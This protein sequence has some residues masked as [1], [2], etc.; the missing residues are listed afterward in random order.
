MNATKKVRKSEKVTELGKCPSCGLPLY[1]D[2]YGS[3]PLKD[4]ELK[5]FNDLQE[6]LIVCNSCLSNPED[7][8]P[9]KIEESLRGSKVKW[10]D[11]DI[12]LAVS[13]VNTY[14][15]L[16]LSHLKNNQPD[17]MEKSKN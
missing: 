7:L 8:S 14:K 10:R 12:R 4:Q 1:E 17:S 16:K 9:E 15:T 13:A 6:R 5:L 3:I 11:Q 2:S